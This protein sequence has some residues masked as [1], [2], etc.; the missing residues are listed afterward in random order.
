MVISSGKILQAL[1]D[2]IDAGVDVAGTYD[3]PEMHGV[4]GDW[5]RAAPGGPSAERLALWNS[6]SAQLVGKASVPFA[7]HGPHNFMHNKAVVA[8]G[9]VA[10]GSFNFSAN[11]THN[12][13]NVLP[14]R[15]C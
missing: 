13:E 11:A 10:T 5:Q 7:A 3:G 9:T 12:A 14:H 15:Q 8:D 2:R 1:A 4:V 6:I